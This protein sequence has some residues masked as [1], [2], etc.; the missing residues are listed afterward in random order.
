M[1]SAPRLLGK[2]ALVT[3]ASSGI[4]RAAA[5]MLAQ[6]GCDVAMNYYTLPESADKAAGQI[7]ALGRK[8]LQ[9][10]GILDAVCP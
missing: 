1:N 9:K 8:A 5:I 6:T 2:K 7:R 10:R 4:G 3:G